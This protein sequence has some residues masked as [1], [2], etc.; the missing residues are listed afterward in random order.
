MTSMNPFNQNSDHQDIIST[1]SLHLIIDSN[2]D[3]ELRIAENIV[4]L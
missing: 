3:T 4:R 1:Y 2:T